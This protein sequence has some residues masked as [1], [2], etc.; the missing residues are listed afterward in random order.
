[1]KNIVILGSTGS[2]GTQTLEVCREQST[3]ENKLNVLAISANSNVKLILEQYKEHRPKF[4]AMMDKNAAL[5]LK[6][7]LKDEDVTVLAG[8]EGFRTIS[9]LDEADIVLTSVVGMVGLLPTVDAIKAGKD[10]ALANKETLVVAGD[11]IMPLAKEYGVKILPVDSEH[12]AIFQALNGEDYSKIKRIILTASGGAFRNKTLDYL[13]N[14]RVEDALKH[15]NWDMGAKI[16]IDSSTLVNKGLEL[17]EASHLFNVDAKNIDVVVHK[18]SIIHSLVEFVDSSV[19]AQ[20]GHPT[21]KLPISYALNYPHR[22]STDYKSL[23]LWELGS[24]HFEKPDTKTF[25]A[26]PLAYEAIKAGGTMPTVYNMANEIAVAKFLRKEIKYL[27]IVDIIESCM[28][29]HNNEAIKDTRQILEVA[30]WT[31]KY[32]EGIL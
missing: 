26:L 22:S 20:L 6:G 12:S 23:D 1:M 7:L 4:I 13:K 32:I 29:K 9:T 11:I 21:M 2:I 16:T 10:I 19:I 5:E 25:R 31:E 30:S 27:Q 3:G 17:I 28:M 18:E 8:M 15:P 14:V 24:L